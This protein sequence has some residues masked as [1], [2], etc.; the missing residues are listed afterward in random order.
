MNSNLFVLNTCYDWPKNVGWPWL[1]HHMTYNLFGTFITITNDHLILKVLLPLTLSSCL[2][3]VINM[4]SV[5]VV[6]LL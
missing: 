5:T 6:V 2:K 4:I 3:I 1:F